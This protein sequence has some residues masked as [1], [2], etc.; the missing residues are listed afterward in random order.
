MRHIIR[1]SAG[2]DLASGLSYPAGDDRAGSTATS[3]S[4]AALL[5]CD[6]VN[7]RGWAWSEEAVDGASSLGW[8]RAVTA[9]FGDASEDF[10]WERS[11]H[12]VASPKFTRTHSPSVLKATTSLPWAS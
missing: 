11:I 2:A 5:T 9:G 3:R 4:A 12:P 8:E 1:L 7:G 6:A 10:R